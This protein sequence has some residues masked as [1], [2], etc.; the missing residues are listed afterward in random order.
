MSHTEADRIAYIKDLETKEADHKN[1]LWMERINI[2]LGNNPEIGS[3]ND[4]KGGYKYYITN[5]V[6]ETIAV[7]PLAI[8]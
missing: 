3:L 2:W 5:S 1:K 8:I 6:G 7:P 4:G